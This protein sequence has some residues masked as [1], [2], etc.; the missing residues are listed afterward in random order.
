[1]ALDPH[2]VEDRLERIG[3]GDPEGSGGLEDV[4]VQDIG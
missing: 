4:E 2:H 1:L 3:E